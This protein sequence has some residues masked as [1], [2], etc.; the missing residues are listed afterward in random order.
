VTTN[1]VTTAV[2]TAPDMIYRSFLTEIPCYITERVTYTFKNT[3][4][5]M[6]M[7][8]SQLGFH[9]MATGASFCCVNRSQMTG[10]EM[11]FHLDKKNS[12]LN[13]DA[14]SGT[15]RIDFVGKVDAMR[16]MIEAIELALRL[17]KTVGKQHAA[18]A[19]WTGKEIKTAPVEVKP[20]ENFHPEFYPFIKDIDTYIDGFMKSDNNVLILNGDP[21]LGKSTF[22]KYLIARAQT[23][24]MVTY[25]E[26]L[27]EMDQFYIDFAT[28]YYELM[29]L[30]DADLILGSRERDGNK[31]MSKILNI[32]DGI[33]AVKKKIIF[34]ANLNSLSDIDP[35]LT[36]PGRCYDI[37][38]FRPLTHGE[39]TAAAKS[40]GR[41]LH[42]VAKEY[43]VAEIFA[44]K[45][46]NS[47]VTFLDKVGFR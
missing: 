23:D 47:N 40:V 20:L 38:Q 13:I 22:I 5:E 37:L 32:S 8:L 21:G 36:R 28:G 10:C 3:M 39:A 7:A 43:T 27:M 17:N 14:T 19:F 26:Q 46:N 11:F 29:V 41:T 2:Y 1:N 42:K 24:V 9:Y 35:A 45:S 12:T 33:L 18:W 30:E 25:D 4:E 34:T 15:V 31:I 6:L 44:E 16:E